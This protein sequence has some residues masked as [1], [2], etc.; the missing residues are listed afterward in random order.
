MNHYFGALKPKVDKRDYLV[1]A[2]ASELPTTFAHA[3]LSPVKNQ[4]SVSSCV[5]HATAVI[6]EMLNKTETGKFIPMSTDFIYGMQ[7]I[8]FNRL[9]K[10]MYLRDACKIVEKYGDAPEELVNGNTEQ[11]KCTA[12]LKE[13]LTEDIYNKI[14]R[15]NAEKVLNW[16]E[17]EL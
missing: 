12:E 6:L 9:D 16:K 4:R 17:Q 7:G 8:E 2:G 1:A 13:T 15:Y 5:A 11:P 10:G 14:C 3:D